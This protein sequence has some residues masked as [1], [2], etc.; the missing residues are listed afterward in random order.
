LASGK[1]IK[2]GGT[3][4]NRES[5]QREADTHLVDALNKLLKGVTLQQLLHHTRLR[6]SIPATHRAA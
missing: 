3:P 2:P 1:E 6:G 5:N 4:Q